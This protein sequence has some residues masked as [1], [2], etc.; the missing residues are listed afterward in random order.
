VSFFSTHLEHITS[1]PISFY[2]AALSTPTTQPLF[3]GRYGSL[4]HQTTPFLVPFY[5]KPCPQFF[6]IYLVMV[7]RITKQTKN[8]S[9]QPPTSR[10]HNGRTTHT[11]VIGLRWQYSWQFH[12]KG[13]YNTVTSPTLWVEYRYND[14]TIHKALFIIVTFTRNVILHSHQ[15]SLETKH[16]HK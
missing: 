16:A 13:H 1:F 11:N 15:T 4:R 2:Q 7:L 8:E 3:M 5:V 12:I 9:N 14:E 10:R 6:M